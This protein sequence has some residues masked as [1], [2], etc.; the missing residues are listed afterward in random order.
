MDRILPTPW[1]IFGEF[2]RLGATAFGGPSM[3]VYIRELAVEKKHWLSEEEFRQGA[4]LCQMIPGATAMQAAAYVGLRAGGLAGAAASFLG[5]GLPA[6]GLMFCFA[7]LY[8]QT[9]TLP[10]VVSVFSGLQAVVVA[11]V[12]NA[13]YSFGKTTLKNW[14]HLAIAAAAGGMF[15]FN[16]HPGLVILLAGGLGWLILP[17]PT[18]DRLKTGVVRALELEWQK[19]TLILGGVLAG[20]AGLYFGAHDLFNLAFL[21]M[22]VD[23]MAFGGGFASVPLMYHEVVAVFQWMDGQTFMNGI[24]LGQVTPG[25]IVITATFI[26]YL[27]QGSFGAIVATLAVFTP[28]FLLVVGL[29]PYYSRF[30]GS[31]LLH[32]LQRGVLCSFVGLLISVGVRLGTQVEWDLVHGLIALVGLAALLRKVDILWIVAAGIGLSL[33]FIR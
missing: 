27:L 26:G 2:L 30:S 29:A 14:R 11:I 21:M 6:F 7:F 17:Q 18:L 32:K 8:A 33:L 16:V 22:R 4:A 20:M 1:Q 12:A 24:V 13:A 28:S 31:A 9:G 23:L 3:V 25:P 5:F 19:L 15:W 10:A